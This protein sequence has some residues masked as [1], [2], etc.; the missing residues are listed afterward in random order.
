MERLPPVPA[1][2][3]AVSSQA[4][5]ADRVHHIRAIETPGR[6][7]AAVDWLIA[8]ERG[9][10][11]DRGPGWAHLVVRTRWIRFEDDVHLL[12]D[13][14]VLHARSASRVGRG[15]LGA[16][17]KRLERLRAALAAS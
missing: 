8:N 5:P 4:D 13:G 15:D 10:V 1:T 16:N 7:D 6:L 2:P 17:R 14:R 9:E 3:N 12:D 11:L